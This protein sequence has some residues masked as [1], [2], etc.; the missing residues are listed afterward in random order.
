MP[1]SLLVEQP[2]YQVTEPVSSWTGSSRHRTRHDAQQQASLVLVVKT[3][4]ISSAASLSILFDHHLPCGGSRCSNY[5]ACSR[6]ASVH[7][8]WLLARA[9]LRHAASVRQADPRAKRHA[10]AVGAGR[11]PMATMWLFDWVFN[12]LANL[13][14]YHKSAKILF[15]GLDNPARRRCCTCSRRTACRSTSRRCT[16]TRTS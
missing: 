1:Q 2:G 9:P 5:E 7:A 4:N 6:H 10:S 3:T 12:V 11:R 13:G 8:C 14:L 15:L 16:R